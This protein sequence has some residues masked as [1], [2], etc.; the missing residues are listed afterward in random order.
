MLIACPL[1]QEQGLGL[2]D[3][4]FEAREFKPGSSRAI[5][6]LFEDAA[7]QLQPAELRQ[8]EHSF[9]FRILPA[10]VDERAAAGEDRKSTRLNSSHLGISY[11]VFC[12]KKKKKHNIRMHMDSR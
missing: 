10:L 1:V 9:D 7:T 6:K 4:S 11:A 3:A 5:L 2:M 12:L 8:D